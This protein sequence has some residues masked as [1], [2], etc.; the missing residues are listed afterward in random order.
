MRKENR[1]K[2]HKQI[3]ATIL[4]LPPN[5]LFFQL[6]GSRYLNENSEFVEDCS[7]HDIAKILKSIYG[8]NIPLTTIKVALQSL[9]TRNNYYGKIIGKTLDK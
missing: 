3:L 9:K 8:Y 5:T 6:S 1:E 2:F 7:I 4:S